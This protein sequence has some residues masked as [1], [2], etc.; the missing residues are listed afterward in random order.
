MQLQIK[1]WLADFRVLAVLGLMGTMVICG[2]VAILAAIFGR[3]QASAPN[4]RRSLTGYGLARKAVLAGCIIVAGYAATVVG[5]SLASREKTLPVGQEKYFCEV[6]CH[7]AYSVT[8]MKIVKTIGE[9]PVAATPSGAFY[10]VT[11]RTRFDEHTISPQ[12]GDAPLTPS[13]RSVALEDA[14]GRRYA[15]SAK[16]QLALEA[17]HRDGKALT[18]PLRPGQWY[19]TR[20]AFDLPADAGAPRLLLESPAQPK[21]M[22]WIAVGDEESLLHKRVYLQLPV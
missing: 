17:G 19:L 9:G 20:L 16:G 2:G 10:V 8:E 4:A 1:Q 7:L 18:M 13:P 3:T 22:G 15:P 11:I 6:D 14:Q 21:W 12:R 5:A